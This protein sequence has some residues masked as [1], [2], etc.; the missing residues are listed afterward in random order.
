[1]SA[2]ELALGILNL[3]GTGQAVDSKSAAQLLPLWQLMDELSVNASASPEEIVAVVG[4]IK[5][6]MTAEQ[7]NTIDKMQ[8]TDLSV[9]LAAQGRGSTNSTSAISTKSAQ[10]ST[11]STGQGTVLTSTLGGPPPGE[12]TGGPGPSGNSQQNTSTIKSSNG[13]GTTSLVQQVIQLLQSKIQS[14][15]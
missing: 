1:M 11:G 14:S 15:T 6:A 9:V 7:I 5:A 3:E 4:S 2:N 8:L 10:T 12:I 13:T